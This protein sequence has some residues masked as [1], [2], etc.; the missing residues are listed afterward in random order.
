MERTSVHVGNRG[1]FRVLRVNCQEVCIRRLNI[2]TVSAFYHLL[3]GHKALL[4]PLKRVEL[5]IDQPNAVSSH[6]GGTLTFPR[7][8]MRAL[9]SVVLLPGA[10]VAS[11]TC[12][13]S[14]AGGERI[15]AGKHDALS[16]RMILPE[17][18]SGLSLN[19]IEGWKSRRLGMC[20]SR[21]RAFLER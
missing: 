5:I 15:T 20:I 9:R 12:V 14:R 21:C 19:E 2:T 17:A 10:A 1:I 13:S 18:S 3:E 4:V 8:F 7:P 16:C 11:M 6:Y